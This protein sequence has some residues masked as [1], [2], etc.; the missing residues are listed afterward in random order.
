[1]WKNL[2][3][4]EVVA[5]GAGKIV[6]LVEEAMDSNYNLHKRR[7][8]RRRRK[9]R[10]RL[11]LKSYSKEKYRVHEPLSLAPSAVDTMS[12]PHRGL[13]LSGASQLA[14]LEY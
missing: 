7:R 2:L 11:R 12:H 10:R 1:M 5:L 6:P 3:S 4:M 13:E 14:C 9:R 8:K